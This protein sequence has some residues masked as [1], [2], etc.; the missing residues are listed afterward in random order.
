MLIESP[1]RNLRDSA[2]SSKPS[3]IDPLDL[4]WSDLTRRAF[5]RP[6]RGGRPIRV[7]LALGKS[8]RHYDLLIEQSPESPAVVVNVLPDDMLVA[9]PAS[10]QQWAG[11]AYHLG[12]LHVPVQ[13]VGEEIVTPRD[14]PSE[15]AFDRVGVPFIVEL[16]RFEPQLR[17]L[18]EIVMNRPD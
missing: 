16:R 17:S 5:R 13:V 10:P 2:G 3:A 1:I 8:L 18:V 15:A 9:R 14:G 4:H 7:L 12:D 11:I 6:T